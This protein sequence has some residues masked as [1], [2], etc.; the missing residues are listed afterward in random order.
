MP[1]SE[2]ILNSLV[3]NAAEDQ[4]FLAPAARVKGNGT[5]GLIEMTDL[6]HADRLRRMRE[7]TLGSLHSWELVTAVDGPGIRMTI[8]LAGCGLRCLYCHNPDTFQMR[9]GEP[10]EVDDLLRRIKR[11]RKTLNA[12]GGGITISG[13]EAMMQPRFVAKLLE[14]AKELGVHT[15]VDTS[16]F[17]GRN[18]TEAMLDNIDLVLLDVKA[19][20]PELYKK[21]T[22]GDLQP[23]IDF[24]DRLAERGIETW[25]RF[26]LVPGLTDSEENV[27]AV[28][29]I[30]EK[31]PNVS[32]VEVL[33][34]HQMGRDKWKTLGL[35]YELNDT[36]PPDKEL[37][38]RTRE[39]FRSHGLTV[40]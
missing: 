2:A 1:A 32:R 22:S 25:I 31:W 15:C 40:Y 6:E 21:V 26:V 38:E 27:E 4:D 18:V 8:F 36:Q 23:T 34:F 35:K 13:G 9:D 24:G 37:I 14:G 12:S 17:L 20:I 30:V 19:G 16:G 7:G 3:A 5:A 29:Q 39:I 10:V 28:A 11:Y 33:P